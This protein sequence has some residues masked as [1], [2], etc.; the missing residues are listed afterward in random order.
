MK[1]RITV[2]GQV[3]T[4]EHQE[5]LLEVLRRNGL[6]P[7]VSCGSNGVC[8][9]CLVMVNGEEVRSCQYA[10]DSDISVTLPQRAKLLPLE[11]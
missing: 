3:I 7:D 2:S 9:K 4:A 8:G 5:S 10:V 6:A 1:R 11:L